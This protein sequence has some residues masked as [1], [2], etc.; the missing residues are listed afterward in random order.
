MLENV[1]LVAIGLTGLFFGG[2]WLVLGASR[3][4]RSLGVSGL[5]VG[6]TVVAFGTSSPELL[7]SVQAAL[8]GSSD[9]SV[10]N[11]VGSNISN[12]GLILGTTALVFP[13][14]V[15]ATLIRREIPIMIGITLLTTALAFINAD[16]GRVDGVILLVSLVAFISLMYWLSQHDDNEK[17]AVVE[18]NE[19][20]DE[21]NLTGKQRLIELGRLIAGLVVLVVGARLTVDGAVEIARAMN[22][23]ELAIGISLIAIGTS[24][25][26]LATSVIAALRKQNDIAIGNIVGSNIFNLLLI[27]GT[28]AIIR[29]IEVNQRVLEFD[30]L[31]MLGFSFGLIPL[32]W[33]GGRI[34]RW[35]ATILVLAYA[36]FIVL[37]LSV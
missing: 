12:I 20:K 30:L 14:T 8:D 23:S 31:V 22:V 35:E 5:I 27:L 6:L 25:P 9:I 4:A 11:V 7:V 15:R 18:A 28:T 21:A 1:L 26:E 13:V 37:A 19:S 17:P 24:L 32:T 2:D 36:V 10:G 16:I 29:P 34:S 33:T 3:L